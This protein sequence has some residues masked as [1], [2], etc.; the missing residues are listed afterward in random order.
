MANSEK[1]PIIA[2]FQQPNIMTS[3][4]DYEPKESTLLIYYS[5]MNLPL[6]LTSDYPGAIKLFRLSVLTFIFSYE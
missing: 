6:T 5:L 1:D 4:S 3:S 2:H